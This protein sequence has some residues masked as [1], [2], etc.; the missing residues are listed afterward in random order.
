ML[1]KT[2]LSQVHHLIEAPSDNYALIGDSSSQTGFGTKA[3]GSGNLTYMDAT[4]SVQTQLDAKA[5]ATPAGIG[6]AIDL[7]GAAVAGT[8]TYTLASTGFALANH[9]LIIA[10]FTNA[11]TG[12][13]T[14]N[15]NGTGAKAIQYK[16]SALASGRIP[17]GA[18]VPLLYNGTLWEMVG[19]WG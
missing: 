11:N 9:Q 3:L 19:Y 4:S 7:T 12:A 16:G 8:D 15:I 2:N 18:F 5:A 13:A 1:N 17:A 14:I 6:T 10:K